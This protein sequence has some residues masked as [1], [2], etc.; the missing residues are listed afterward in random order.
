MRVLKKDGN[1]IWTGRIVGDPS[2]V[3]RDM[4]GCSTN[5]PLGIGDNWKRIEITAFNKNGKV[6][7]T[8]SET[9]DRR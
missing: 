6:V 2:V 4:T 3:C 9:Y 5:G 8:F 1:V 7:A